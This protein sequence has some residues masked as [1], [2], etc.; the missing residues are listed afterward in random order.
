MDFASPSAAAFVAL[1]GKGK[2]GA[3]LAVPARGPAEAQKI[4][5]ALGKKITTRGAATLVEGNTGGRGWLY[6]AG[7]IV[8]LSDEADALARGT[9]LTLEARRAGRRRRH[10][11]SVPRRDRARERHRR[12]E[13][14]RPLLEG[15]GS[16][17]RRA[18]RPRARPATPRPASI[19]WRRWA[20]RSRSR[21][22]RRASRSAWSRIRRK[23][24][25]VRA[26]FNARPGTKLETVAKE[27]K[28]FKL[29]PAVATTSAGGRFLDRREQHRAVLAR[30]ARDLPRSAGRGQAEGR[31]RRRW[32]TTTRWWR[33]WRASSRSACR[34]TRRR[35]T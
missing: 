9:M 11:G 25:I 27:V 17:S 7:N 20:R 30:R 3:V 34:C 6:R 26:R 22:T 24:L 1:D 10:G 28:P 21:A 35:P 19:R 5:D 31:G 16:R 13:R 33:R 2:S 4:I 8:V 29:D 32:P 18:A 14:D 12:Q 15:D 23:G